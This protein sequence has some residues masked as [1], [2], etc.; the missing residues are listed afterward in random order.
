MDSIRTGNKS[1]TLCTDETITKG[2]IP[3]AVG[4]YGILYMAHEQKS[5]AEFGS[6]ESAAEPEA[7][8][9]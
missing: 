8:L 6:L 5:N 1:G 3:Y 7:S 9:K 2:K 4:V